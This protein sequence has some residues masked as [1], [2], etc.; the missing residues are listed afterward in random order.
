MS[1]IRND[2]LFLRLYESVHECTSR[3]VEHLSRVDYPWVQ[4]ETTSCFLR[5]YESVHKCTSTPVEHL[6]RMDHP[7]VQSGTFFLRLYELV[8]KCTSPP[9]EHLPRM[10]DP[11]HAMPWTFHPCHAMPWTFQGCNLEQLL[12]FK[13]LRVSQQVHQSTSRTPPTHG[14][15]MYI[16]VH[17][18]M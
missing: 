14:R 4:S 17:L 16:K 6:P 5:L 3:P 10:D 13:A 2:S 8:H 1:P 18:T 15:S 12:V 11:C 7:R 9:V